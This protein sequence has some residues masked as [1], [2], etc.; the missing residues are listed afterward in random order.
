M[1]EEKTD[2]SIKVYHSN[3]GVAQEVAADLQHQAGDGDPKL[4]I[5]FASS[6]YDPTVLAASMKRSFS[7]TT[8]IGCTTAGEIV[9][10][11]MLTQSVVAMHIGSDI[12][13]DLD[14]Q[15]LDQIKTQDS[16]R[17]AFAAFSN[18]FGIS[19]QSMD[20]EKYVGIILVD[21]L[22][23]AE[24][25]LM[26]R[27]GDLTDVTFIGG[28][29]GDDLKFKETRVFADG[30]AKSNCAVLALLKLKKG[31][32]II[33]TQ[34]FCPQGRKLKAT[35]VDEASRRVKEFNHKPA[36]QAYA[37]A[38]GVSTE[39]AADRFMTNPLGLMVGEEPYIRSPQRFDGTDIVF[40]CN[41]KQ[42]TELDVMSSMDLVRDTRNAVTDKERAL[43][44]IAGIIDFHCILRTL[45]LREKKLGDAYGAIFTQIP[46]IGFSTYGEEYIG[47]INQT[48][49]MLVFK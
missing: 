29:A 37:E 7:K 20:L 18:H 39:V 28:S 2:V 22:S 42:G 36:A 16:V 11:K 24:E 1:I 44:G 26:E 40:Y 9:S 48:S 5:Y 33:K 6:M 46:T 45:E 8:V 27:I 43:G 12:I 17:D 49:T 31:F 10:G 34:S 35:A 13:E 14:V 32:D 30:Q 38:L 41:V 3:K 15:V 23:G 19:M 4:I 25:R 47:H 21:G